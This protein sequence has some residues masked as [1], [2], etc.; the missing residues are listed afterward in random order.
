MRGRVRGLLL[1]AAILSL[2]GCAE[3]PHEPEVVAAGSVPAPGASRSKLA[4]EA[5]RL[6]EADRAFAA[7]AL[8]KGAPEAF[9]D[10]FDSQGVRLT[11]EGEPPVGPDVAAQSLENATMLLSWDPRYAE[12]FAPGDWG[13]TWGDW[14]AYEPGA[15]GKR[16]GQG[17]YVNV[18]KKQ[19]DGSWKVHMN[20]LP[21]QAAP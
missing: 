15:G 5:D 3:T 13:V 1:C 8:E 12:V 2:A 9:H 19:R 6:L 7:R 4:Q 18:W 14:Q 17:R 21:A 20:L 11:F 16:L 10:Y